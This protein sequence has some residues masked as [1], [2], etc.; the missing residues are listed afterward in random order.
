L[1]TAPVQPSRVE[2]SKTGFIEVPAFLRR[3]SFASS[4][5]IS[6]MK[7]FRQRIS[8]FGGCVW[9]RIGAALGTGAL[10]FQ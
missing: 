3:S 9:S 7:M 2:P 4:G 6:R 5:G 8:S 1:A 10:R